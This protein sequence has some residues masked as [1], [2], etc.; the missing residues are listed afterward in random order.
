M[1]RFYL[2]Y[3]GI[4]VVLAIALFVLATTVLVQWNISTMSSPLNWLLL[5][6][7]L[8]VMQFCYTPIMR[9]LGI[10]QYYSPMFLGIKLSK[11]VLDLHSGTTFDYLL[12]MK[13]SERG[14]PAQRKIL[15]YFLEGLLTI[16]DKIEKDQIPPETTIIGT[17]Y[18]FSE[19]TV[20]KW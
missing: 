13:F 16:I 18:F 15:A 14:L 5:P 17:S 10:Y 20:K 4:R 9:L 3:M 8:S 19:R 6:L 7:V 12:N 2:K 11:Q 1:K